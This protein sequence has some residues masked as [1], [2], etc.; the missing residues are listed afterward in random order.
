MLQVQ[1]SPCAPFVP[2]NIV[3]GTAGF[4]RT[5]ANG[6]EVEEA[7]SELEVSGRVWRIA[8]VVEIPLLHCASAVVNKSQPKLAALQKVWGLA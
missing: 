8:H 5:M 4:A 1:I 6:V 3:A 2:S 7:E